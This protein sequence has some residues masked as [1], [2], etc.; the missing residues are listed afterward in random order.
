MERNK[1]SDSFS[2]NKIRGSIAEAACEEHFRLL[3]YTIERTGIEHIAPVFAE[4]I[5]RTKLHDTYGKGM[6]AYLRS[7][8]DFIVSR[9]KG[10]RTQAMFVDAKF[11]YCHNAEQLKQIQSDLSK[12]I[13]VY[14][15][16]H[17]ETLL[18]L[19]TNPTNSDYNKGLDNISLVWLLWSGS[20]SKWV[21]IRE[22]SQYSIY[23]ESD[24][25]SLETIYRSE[26]HPA[27]LGI[28]GQ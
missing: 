27:L 6:S 19:V 2:Q 18:Y 22:S 9:F 26:I 21:P 1:M 20:P 5:G 4:K 15:E 23:V 16:T 13:M 14:K 8:P 7:I 24:N 11:R 17:G 25:C 10:G 28:F 12:Q 3:G